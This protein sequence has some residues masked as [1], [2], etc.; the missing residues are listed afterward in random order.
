MSVEEP[1]IIWTKYDSHMH[2]YGS[3][4]GYYDKFD[5]GG[6]SY[7]Q[8]DK[9]NDILEAADIRE[10]KALRERDALQAKVAA[11]NKMAEAIAEIESVTPSMHKEWRTFAKAYNALA[12]YR[13]ATP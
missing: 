4:L 11:A 13:K 10:L 7:I 2:S 6:K 9:Y 5:N 8:T 3:H 1:L 12:E